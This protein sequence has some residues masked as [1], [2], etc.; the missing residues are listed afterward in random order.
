[1]ISRRALKTLHCPRVERQRRNFS[2]DL[3]YPTIAVLY[4]N[5]RIAK[6]LG[7]RGSAMANPWSFAFVDLP[8]E[9]CINIYEHII[10][11]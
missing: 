1:M 6:L 9:I 4:A 5:S 7:E 8:A 2:V 11:S 3:V 10:Q